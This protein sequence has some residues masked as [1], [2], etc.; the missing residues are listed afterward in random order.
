[1]TRTTTPQRMVSDLAKSKT[2]KPVFTNKEKGYKT[3]FIGAKKLGK[4]DDA[5]W[6]TE[7]ECRNRVKDMFDIDDVECF[8]DEERKGFKPGPMPEMNETSD[9]KSDDGVTLDESPSEEMTEE[10]QGTESAPE[11]SDDGTEDKQPVEDEL[12]DGADIKPKNANS[13]FESETEQSEPTPSVDGDRTYDVSTSRG[14][15]QL[16]PIFKRWPWEYGKEALLEKL[17]EEVNEAVE[18]TSTPARINGNI[19]TMEGLSAISEVVT[20]A[21]VAFKYADMCGIDPGLMAKL[22]HLRHEEQEARYSQV[23]EEDTE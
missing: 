15:V 23:L 17:V 13:D 8:W 12:A 10:A 6:E 19:I 20:V 11:A 7:D 9:V 2:P 1:M 5:V 21:I 22:M 18:G 16:K 4:G 3:G 14:L